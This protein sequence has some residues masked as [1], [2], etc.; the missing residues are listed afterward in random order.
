M[1]KDDRDH[2]WVVMSDG[3]VEGGL[4]SHTKRVV[5][6]S[7]LRLQVGV[8]PLLEQLCCQAGQA[9]AAR[10]MKW[11]LTLTGGKGMD[12]NLLLKHNNSINILFKIFLVKKQFVIN[13]GNSLQITQHVIGAPVPNLRCFISTKDSYTRS[14]WSGVGTCQGCQTESVRCE[15]QRRNCSVLVGGFL[16]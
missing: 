15:Q 8:G 6:Q 7:L 10:C 5:R 11:A 3:Q 12:I 4:H 13:D 2:I 1:F 14:R 9:T 16:M